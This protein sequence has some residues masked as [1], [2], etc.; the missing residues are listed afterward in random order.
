MSTHSIRSTRVDTTA[1][2]IGASGLLACAWLALLFAGGAPASAQAP[3]PH[4]GGG[5][6]SVPALPPGDG[7]MTIDVVVK[8]SDAPAAGVDV[9]LYALSPDGTPGLG[10]G[11]TDTNGRF[12]FEGLST[13]GAIT[14]LAGAN[15][16]GVPF[17]ERVAFEP[18]QTAQRVRL[19]VIRA[20]VEGPPIR[21][22]ETR[23]Q[24]GWLGRLLLFDV[25]V[26]V[27]NPGETVRKIDGAARSDHPPLFEAALP[28]QF[29]EFAEAAVGFADGLERDGTKLRFF[30]P[31]YP[32]QQEI[33]WRFTY[34]VP[35][36]AG[37]TTVDID[38]PQ[39]RGSGRLSVLT[40]SSG[41]LLAPSEE[42]AS[43]PV[44]RE[45]VLYDLAELA[46]VPPGG[47]LDLKLEV[48]ASRSDTN[49]IDVPRAD[50]WLDHD[51]AVVEVRGQI[52]LEVAPG[53]HV[54]GT[55]EAPLIHIELPEGARLGGVSAAT[56]ALGIGEG[57]DG[58]IDV[59][60][61]IPPGSSSIEFGYEVSTGADGALDLELGLSRPVDVVN[62]LV[63]D[64]GIAVDSD[65]LHRRRPF[66]QGTR[67]YLHRRAFQVGA[68]ERID[69][70]LAPL[71]DQAAPRNRSLLAVLVLGGGAA[72]FLVAPL[73]ARPRD[74]EATATGDG[75]QAWQR[76]MIYEAIRDLDLDLE[77]GKVSEQDHAEM[78]AKLR[79][80]AI[81]LVRAER[82]SRAASE[83]TTGS[84][85]SSGATAEGQGAGEAT[86]PSAPARGAFCP[87]CGGRVEP[88]W[89]FCSHCGG[90]LTPS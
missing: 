56:Q 17:G 9:A 83:A 76:E 42:R 68:N 73:R 13:D 23:V 37:G 84:A 57:L 1:R 77:T 89:Q 55:P 36:D 71:D 49:A 7:Q 90:E 22:E 40:P 53:P 15:Y 44:E 62:V 26:L 81:E 61:P 88:D 80:E 74:D 24:V 11:V 48:P 27:R 59:I 64:N 63:A 33:R 86:E 46:A 28:A 52:Q 54:Q 34:A 66:R 31:V 65:Q 67:N 38:L 58:G 70:R 25:T 18:G 30:G 79:A 12:V 45:G 5:A 82:A 75:E 19:E 41:P 69:V 16:E 60:G 87:H 4:A 51:D 21:V 29:V 50:W 20:S 8:G 6:S 85:A 35:D 3:S 32:G 14:Y 2:R 43:Q 47:T 39:P 78:R 72:W 10:S